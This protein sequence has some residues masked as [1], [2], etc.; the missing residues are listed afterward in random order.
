MVFGSNIS[1]PRALFFHIELA[2]GRAGLIKLFWVKGSQPEDRVSTRATG[3]RSCW[4]FLL[5]S[6]SASWANDRSHMRNCRPQHA[7]PNAPPRGCH[8]WLLNSCHEGLVQPEAPRPPAN[9]SFV[10]AVRPAAQ[11][12]LIFPVQSRSAALTSIL[13]LSG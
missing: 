7:A 3:L 11:T 12:R 2:A 9:V 8:N 4:V 10:L 13:F 6:H 1:E 5:L